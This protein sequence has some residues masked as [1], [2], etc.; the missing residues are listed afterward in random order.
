MEGVPY[1][2]AVGSL[3]Y[4]MV[5]TRADLAFAVSMVSQ[6]MSRAGPTHWSAVKRIMRYLQ[7]T[8]EFKLCLGGKDITLK[9]YCDADW[10]GDTNER[11][12][13]T[14]YVFFVGVGAISWNC[15]RQPTIALSTTEAEYMA[16]SQSTKEAIW[17]RKLLADVGFSQ[18]G[19][20]TIMCDNQGCIAFA[21]N[22]THH[23][24]TEHIVL[25]FNRIRGKSV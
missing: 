1:K 19:A 22:P 7:G 20:T 2:A 13:T 23:A 12:S 25:K 14:G 24:R 17:L 18:E 11:R 16:T 4:A 9:G 3:M 5:G 15:K 6:F 21:K 8:C 10:A